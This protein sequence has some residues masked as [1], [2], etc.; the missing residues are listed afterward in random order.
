MNTQPLFRRESTIRRALKGSVCGIALAGAAL[1]VTAQGI[2]KIKGSYERV[3]QGDGKYVET[4]DL[5]TSNKI[6][7]DWYIPALVAGA[8]AGAYVS[9]RSRW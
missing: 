8:A 9:I 2:G 1:F 6:L 4:V 3:M 5:D 7:A